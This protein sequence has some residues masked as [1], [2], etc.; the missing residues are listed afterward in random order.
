MPSGWESTAVFYADC[1][2]KMEENEAD[3]N[4]RTEEASAERMW[5]AEERMGM[6]QQVQDFRT[7][8][9]RKMLEEEGEMSKMKPEFRAEGE[10]R[11][12][13]KKEASERQAAEKRRQTE[14]QLRDVGVAH[15][16]GEASMRPPGDHNPQEAAVR[17]AVASEMT[18]GERKPLQWSQLDPDARMLAIAAERAKLRARV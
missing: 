13:E 1:D 8:C 4:K 10:R 2:R 15:G 18:S 16:E 14:E 3:M 5:L 11:V 12:V 7:E 17:S 9:E 6:A